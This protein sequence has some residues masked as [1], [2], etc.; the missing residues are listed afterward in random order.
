V[1][2]S[3][4]QSLHR[5]LN[6]NRGEQF[7]AREQQVNRVRINTNSLNLLLGVR[8]HVAIDFLCLR[9]AA[10]D[11]QRLHFASRGYRAA[12]V[13]FLRPIPRFCVRDQSHTQLM[14][15]ISFAS[16]TRYRRSG[17]SNRREY[18]MAN[19]ASR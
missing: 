11:F 17:L 1:S 14:S 13:R 3:I 5:R 12:F 18:A 16:H 2:M 10:S 9:V 7:Q 8:K 4:L 15:L 6:R 19:D